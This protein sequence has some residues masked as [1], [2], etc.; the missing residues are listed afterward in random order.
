M[1]GVLICGAVS[2]AQA[3]SLQSV[4]LLGAGSTFVGPLMLGGWIP[5]YGKMHSNVQIS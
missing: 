3:A 5:A 4:R 2:P 1:C